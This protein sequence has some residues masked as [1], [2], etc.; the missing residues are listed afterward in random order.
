MRDHKDYWIDNILP[1]LI[2]FHEAIT[3]FRE[4]DNL[5]Y[6]WLVSSEDEKIVIV[7]TLCP[8][9]RGVWRS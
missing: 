2:T 7:D 8:H 3:R 6:R 1:K 5:R 4:D 9:L